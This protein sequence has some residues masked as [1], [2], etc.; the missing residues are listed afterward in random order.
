[1]FG[2]GLGD[3]SEFSVPLYSTHWRLRVGLTGYVEGVG[4]KMASL[5]LAIFSFVF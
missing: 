4:G 2:Q 3:E 1:M 5:Y